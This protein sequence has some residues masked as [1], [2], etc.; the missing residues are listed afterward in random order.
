MRFGI[1]LIC[2]LRGC[3]LP[4]RVSR[5]SHFPINFPLV[6]EDDFFWDS[7]SETIL[8]HMSFCFGVCHIGLYH[9]LSLPL[10]WLDIFMPI[11]SCWSL[12]MVRGHKEIS[13]GPWPF[14]CTYIFLTSS[15][16]PSMI[17]LLLPGYYSLLCLDLF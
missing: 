2:S 3:V 17:V 12:V 4:V 6:Y 15:G 11:M 10:V 7:L 9:Y 8:L 1:A 13:F 16:K 14:H 5:S